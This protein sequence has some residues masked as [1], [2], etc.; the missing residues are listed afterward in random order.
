MN[1][2]VNIRPIAARILV[3]RDPPTEKIGSIIIPENA[4]DKLTRG[5]VIAVGPGKVLD[6]GRRVEPTLKVGDRIIFGKYSGCDFEQ[7]REE[8]LFMTEEEVLGVIEDE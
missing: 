1:V 5:T 8:R 6:S 7:D 4:R 2:R 3:R